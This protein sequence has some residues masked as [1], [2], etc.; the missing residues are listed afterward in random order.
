MTYPKNALMNFFLDYK[1]GEYIT[2]RRLKEKAAYHLSSLYKD[3][4]VNIEFEILCFSGFLKADSSKVV[5]VSPAF[6][7]FENENGDLFHISEVEDITFVTLKDDHVLFIPS[8]KRVL[9]CNV[10]KIS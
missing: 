3:S 9:F 6:L 4:P 2:G 5:P 10:I 7:K 8:K 1:P